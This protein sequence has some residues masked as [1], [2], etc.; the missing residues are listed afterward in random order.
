M[1]DAAHERARDWPLF[2][3]R[4][5]CDEIT[6]RPARE[7][8]LPRLAVIQPDD[9]ENDPRAEALPGLGVA[10]HRRRL[11]Y[12]G[13]WRSW[14]TWSPSL[15]CLNFVVELDG[16]VVGVQSLEAEDFLA[17]RTVDSSSWLVRSERGRGVGVTMRMAVLGLAFGHLHAQAAVS[18]ARRDNG[19]SLG[20]SRHLGYRENGVSLNASGQGLV[21]LQHMRLTADDWDASGRSRHVLVTGFEPCLPW[22]GITPGHTEQAL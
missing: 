16:V 14:G 8:D 6:L 21:E 2:D 12:Q 3:L 15:W 1:T 13:Y 22:F 9:Y 7:E 17:V 10:Q 5:S 18:S 20:V 4:L 19:A 11:V